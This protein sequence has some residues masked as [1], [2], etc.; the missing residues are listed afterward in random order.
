LIPPILSSHFPLSHSF[1]PRNLQ[2]KKTEDCT[3][4]RHRPLRPAPATRFGLRSARNSPY[5]KRVREQFKNK[6]KSYQ[7]YVLHRRRTSVSNN[8]CILASYP[9][10]PATRPYRKTKTHVI[11]EL[12]GASP[13]NAARAAPTT[14]AL[15]YLKLPQKQKTL[16]V[17][18]YS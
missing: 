13:P 11:L 18:K 17:E 16:L 15:S 12:A 2:N 14:V 8:P 10:Q 1:L 4:S 7:S 9:N 6:L 5:P 3:Q